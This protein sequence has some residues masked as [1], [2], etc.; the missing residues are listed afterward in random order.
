MNQGDYERAKTY[1]DNHL[2]IAGELSTTQGIH[3]Q[4][5]AYLNLGNLMRRQRRWDAAIEHYQKQLQ[6]SIEIG[7]QSWEALAYLTIAEVFLDKSDDAIRRIIGAGSIA[8]QMFWQLQGFSESEATRRW[9]QMQQRMASEPEGDLMSYYEEI[10][11]SLD[12]SSKYARIALRLAEQNQLPMI[13]FDAS[14]DLAHIKQ[15]VVRLNQITQPEFSN[16]LLGSQEAGRANAYYFAAIEHL[17][18]ARRKLSVEHLKRQMI[19]RVRPVYSIAITK[20]LMAG[21]PE[22]AYHYLERGKGIGLLDL[23]TE[24]RHQLSRPQR[25]E[26]DFKEIISS[27]SS[28]AELLSPICGKPLTA[29]E[30]QRDV[31]ANDGSLLIEYYLDEISLSAFVLSVDSFQEHPL[32]GLDARLRELQAHQTDGGD[33][34][35]FSS[36]L[37]EMPPESAIAEFWELVKNF[38]RDIGWSGKYDEEGSPILEQNDQNKIKADAGKLYDILIRPLEPMFLDEQGQ[39][40]KGVERLVIVPH[41]IL[42]HLP[43]CALYDTK[44][45]CY[46]IKHIPLIHAPSASVLAECAK[47]RAQNMESV[48]YL[49][50]ANPGNDDVLRGWE[51]HVEQL[52]RWLADPDNR[53]VYIWDAATIEALLENRD[54]TFIVLATHGHEF[55]EAEPFEASIEMGSRSPDLL[56][57]KRLRVRDIFRFFRD[58]KLNC[59]LLCL[60]TCWGGEVNVSPGDELLGLIRAWLFAGARSL[61]VN[62]WPLHTERTESFLD[63]FFDY[64]GWTITN[65]ENGSLDKAKVLQKTQIEWL[66]TRSD[67]ERHPY[68]WAFTLI[69]DHRL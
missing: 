18:D 7:A 15:T 3:E 32:L 5:C 29:T 4:I 12:E 16:T 22:R 65:Q 61:L 17:E 53:Q 46:L 40:K 69:G 28:K 30:V 63:I 49:G 36:P 37:L 60:I 20:M 38:D 56:Q 43:F 10:A 11:T 67:V 66:E 48:K 13:A 31:L 23:V 2:R 27:A 64:L 42:H 14:F 9:E 54:S 50:L 35:Q 57:K 6:C 52:G 45:E 62:H 21:E 41:G 59:S 25:E 39:P 1:F 44:R 51:I 34:T 47:N 24:T 58:T 8:S 68:Y 19:D 26:I 33:A 55:K